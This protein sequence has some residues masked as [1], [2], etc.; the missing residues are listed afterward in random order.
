M[1][2]HVESLHHQGLIS[3]I[4]GSGRNLHHASARNGCYL[5]PEVSAGPCSGGPV[6]PQQAEKPDRD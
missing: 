2:L 3:G 4:I 5:P 6:F 1:T